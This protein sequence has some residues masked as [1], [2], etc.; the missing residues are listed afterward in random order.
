MGG[1]NYMVN[2][3][4]AI[5][6]G[7]RIVAVW[8]TPPI[9]EIN[10]MTGVITDAPAVP[11]KPWPE[12][13]S[14]PPQPSAIPSALVPTGSPAQATSASI[15]PTF[16]IAEQPPSGGSLASPGI[17]VSIRNYSGSDRDRWIDP[18]ERIFSWRVISG[19]A[20]SLHHHA[21]L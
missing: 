15:T 2:P 6:G 17:E 5:V 10:V 16:P 11:V 3:K 9:F 12:P 13:T 18:I 21:V 14:A 4:V 7:N 20:E 19:Y 1:F 8:Y